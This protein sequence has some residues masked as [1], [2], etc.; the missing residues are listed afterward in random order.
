MIMAVYLRFESTQGEVLKKNFVKK[1]ATK[2][3]FYCSVYLD[4]KSV[5][6]KRYTAS[7]SSSRPYW[8]GHV[9]KSKCE[10]TNV[11]SVDR[12]YILLLSF[13]IYM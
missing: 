6:F 5:E 2:Y 10:M 3:L 7:C 12:R 11:S 13:L 4:G 9:L 8:N 1:I